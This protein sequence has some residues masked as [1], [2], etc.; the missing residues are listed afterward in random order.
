MTPSLPLSPTDVG[1]V[2]S[3]Q[4]PNACQ[5][6]VYN[7]GP[8]WQDWLRSDDLM[9]ALEVIRKL[10]RNI[11]V[12]ITG[13]EPFSNFP[14][15]LKAVAIAHDLHLPV[16]V[17]TSAHWCVS[18][19][20]AEQRFNALR[21]AGLLA[22]LISCSP[23]HAEKIPL[24]RTLLAIEVAAEI[25]GP[26]GVIVYTPDWID[27]IWHF[28]LETP[29]SINQY[30]LA[31][32]GE[33]AGLMFWDGYGLISGGRA[34]YNLGRLVELAPAESFLSDHCLAELLFASHSHLDPYGN[35]VSG[36][37]G[38]IRTGSW[39]EIE[40]LRSNLENRI[41]PDLIA[42]LIEGGPYSLYQLAV[43]QY[44]YSPL[45]TGYVGKCH[46]CVDV[47]RH[48]FLCAAGDFP[49]LRPL[50]FYSQF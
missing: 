11:Q 5:H 30:V 12:H 35:Y 4:C 31:Y 40:T 22:V 10:N 26:E 3:Y 47:R 24:K 8:G 33:T 2:L 48:L 15:L 19:D 7:C 45:P 28:G 14:L 50:E 20:L 38:G 29:V 18:A 27:Q 39:R 25:F 42:R 44:Q 6:C 17:E 13:G 23:F 21:K 32:G 46:L 1:L 9:P 37:C 43:D 49:E 36:Y 16:Y 34:G 41:Y